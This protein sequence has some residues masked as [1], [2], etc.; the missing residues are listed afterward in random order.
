MECEVSKNEASSSWHRGIDA[1]FDSPGLK[2][3]PVDADG[4]TQRPLGFR[5]EET[6]AS[7]AG[8]P[9]QDHGVAGTLGPHA[10]PDFEQV[11]ETFHIVGP[12]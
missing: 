3:Y 10:K 2:E 11:H 12:Q 1:A 6:T 9:V 4:S 7:A 8:R 5:G